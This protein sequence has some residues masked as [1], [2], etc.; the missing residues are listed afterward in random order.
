M[1]DMLDMFVLVSATCLANL[2]R[3][4]RFDAS[5]SFQ[6]FGALSCLLAT[7]GFSATLPL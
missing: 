5:A 1:S 3:H 4:V 6:A 7:E 2:P